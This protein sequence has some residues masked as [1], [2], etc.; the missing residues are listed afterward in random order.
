MGRESDSGPLSLSLADLMTRYAH[1]EDLGFKVKQK[2]CA[3]RRE[4][5]VQAVEADPDCTRASLV[6]RRLLLGVFF[7]QV[8]QEIGG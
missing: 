3:I 7:L 1:V 5:L 2:R 4:D 8:R 6:Q